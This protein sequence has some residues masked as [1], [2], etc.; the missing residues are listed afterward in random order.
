MSIRETAADVARRI[1]V[2]KGN[3]PA[4]LV[5]RTPMSS[6]YFCEV[7]RRRMWLSQEE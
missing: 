7:L 2:A 6:M 3:A 5:I 1:D 4:D